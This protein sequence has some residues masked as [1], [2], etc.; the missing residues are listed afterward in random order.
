MFSRAEGNAII[1]P[2]SQVDASMRTAVMSIPY[3]RDALTPRGA[4]DLWDQTAVQRHALAWNWDANYRELPDDPR[5]RPVGM[6]E[7]APPP[8]PPPWKKLGFSLSVPDSPWSVLP[9]INGV[10]GMMISSMNWSG[11][12][13]RIEGV[14]YENR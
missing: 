2:M 14:I 11:S 9:L 4:E 7:D 1:P 13:W 5:L 8:L 10:P 12:Q 3:S 6:P